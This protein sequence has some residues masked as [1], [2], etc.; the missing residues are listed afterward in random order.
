MVVLHRPEL[1]SHARARTFV[2]GRKHAAHSREEKEHLLRAL[3]GAC[4]F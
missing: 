1:Y 4:G 2:V 3:F